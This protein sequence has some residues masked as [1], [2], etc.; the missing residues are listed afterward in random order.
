M[1]AAA[2]APMEGVHAFGGGCQAAW[3]S[4]LARTA[5]EAQLVAC[6]QESL[7]QCLYDNAR[8]LAERLVAAAPSEVRVRSDRIARPVLGGSTCSKRSAAAPLAQAN[9]HLL[10]VCYFHSNQAYRAF[11]LLRS[12]G[13]HHQPAA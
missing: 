12:T 5:M 13:T 10:A 6:I 1:A 7:S 3:S 4:G 11:H 8:W 2:G 9:V